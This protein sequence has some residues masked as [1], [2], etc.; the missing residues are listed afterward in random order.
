MGNNVGN[1]SQWLVIGQEG[2]SLTHSYLLTHSLTYSLT[3]R[4]KYFAL[5]DIKALDCVISADSRRAEVQAEPCR[6]ILF[7]E[8]K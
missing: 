8:K 4:W 3:C 7:V 5:S 1:R 2:Y 6:V